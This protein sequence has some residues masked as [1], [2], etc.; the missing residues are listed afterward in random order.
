MDEV[1]VSEDSVLIRNLT[2]ENEDLVEY[3]ESFE[4][5]ADGLNELIDIA[6]TIRSRFTTDLETQNIQDAA[7][8][9][10]DQMDATLERLLKELKEKA[11]LLVDPENG[12]VIRALDKAT[13]D[14]LKK[15]LAPED[16]YDQGPIA[17]LRSMILQDVNN[18]KDEV[19]G[20]LGEIKSK[21]GI[22]VQK[23]KS[24]AD[25][26]DF[27]GKVDGIIQN[28]ARIYGD[29]AIATGA[30]TEG[31]SAKKGDTEV[32]LN[33]DDT[34]N[35]S[36]KII[37]ESKTDSKFK[38]KPNTQSPKVI[39]DQVKVE[40]NA[41]MELR[42]AKAGV[43]VLDSSGLDMDA[44][45]TWREYEGNKLLIVVDPLTPDA[46]LIQ[47]AYLWARWKAKASVA[48]TSVSIDFEGVKSG[49]EQI[50]L[51]LRDLR[52]VKKAHTE[53]NTLLS[54]ASSVVTNI[55]KD[56]KRLMAE[57]AETINIEISET[58]DDD[59]E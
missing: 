11:D 50:R 13:G 4:D 20:T 42:K 21:L 3:L 47:L 59:D 37:W 51:R 38:G 32:E 18:F 43:L 56:T 33:F 57:L 28:Y 6:L 45:P 17:R 46:D 30:K 40:L 23:R 5:P 10:I 29:T 15:L 44:Q 25:G 22:G 2:I 58:Q 34:G 36:C 35:I 12:P 39:D 31:V 9:V 19:D 52:N 8:N 14:N 1:V 53:V 54:G 24:G 7:T 16:S 55:Q 49:F 26:T 48:T 27:E 41:A